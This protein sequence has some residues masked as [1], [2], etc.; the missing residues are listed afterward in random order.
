MQLHFLTYLH[1]MT[2]VEEKDQKQWC[3]RNFINY[4]SME[5]AFKIYMQLKQIM[6][7][8]H[9]PRPSKI[10]NDAWSV[11]VCKALLYGFFMQVGFC[12]ALCVTHFICVFEGGSQKRMHCRIFDFEGKCD[13][14]AASEQGVKRLP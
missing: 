2:L 5:K 10:T 3:C 14:S 9:L 11:N 4:R 13:C 6:D 12:A 8:L 1:K 7:R